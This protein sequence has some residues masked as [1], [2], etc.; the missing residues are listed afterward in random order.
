MSKNTQQ[1]RKDMIDVYGSE[2]ARL[3][4]KF[5]KGEMTEEDRNEQYAAAGYRHLNSIETELTRQKEELRVAVENHEFK[6]D[7]EEYLPLV[8]AWKG[9]YDVPF[10]DGYKK[11]KD[12]ILTL[13]K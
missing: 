1:E 3:T 12:D 13:L 9:G 10:D 6:V 4:M 7:I 8:K 11:A 5:I 2:I